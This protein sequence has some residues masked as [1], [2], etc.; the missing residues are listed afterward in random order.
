MSLKSQ[1]LRTFFQATCTLRKKLS[2]FHR[3]LWFPPHGRYSIDQRISK[4]QTR[5]IITITLNAKSQGWVGVHVSRGSSPL[6]LIFLGRPGRRA[7]MIEV[8]L[9]GKA[10]ALAVER[11]AAVLSL[12]RARRSD[13]NF[14]DIYS[15]EKLFF[16]L[17]EA[18]LVYGFEIGKLSDFW[19]L[20]GKNVDF[21]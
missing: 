17:Y 13:I 2:N 3:Q 10:R 9:P 11:V 4:T 19:F 15:R 6:H 20:L 1:T 16:T 12:A 18:G 21:I 8:Q 7:T 5:A 14:S